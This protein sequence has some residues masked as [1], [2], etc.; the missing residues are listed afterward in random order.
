MTVVALWL[1][2]VGVAD[3][4]RWSTE[5]AGRMRTVA[6]LA[7]AAA[8]TLVLSILLGFTFW[9]T[10]AW[11]VVVAA[12]VALWLFTSDRALSRTRR[13]GWSLA[14]MTGYLLGLLATSGLAPEASG[15]LHEWYVGLQIPALRALPLEKFL[16]SLAALIFLQSTANRVTRLILVAAGTPAEQG[17]STL[18]G[19][20]IIGPMERTLI[21]ALA[22]T[23][24]L[25]AAA[26]VIA[27][28]GV[29]R[30]PEIRSATENE[31]SGIASVTE[32]FLIGTLASWLQAFALT[33]LL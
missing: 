14:V 10:L 7:T 12:G 29:L 20:R 6:G 21:F 11:T 8:L 33:L 27:A 3:L 1:L 25:T 32:Y 31:H 30:F 5:R 4:V 28:K 2:A 16:L 26:A 19:G 13:T 15:P 17:E 9:A 18:R 23:G 24:Q 22:A